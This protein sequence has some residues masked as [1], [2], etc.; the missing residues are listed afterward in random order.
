[1]YLKVRAGW[2]LSGNQEINDLAI[3]NVYQ[4]VYAKED[5]IWDNPTQTYMLR[6]GTAYDI[7]GNDQ[8]QL[9]SGYIYSPIANDNLMGIN[10]TDQLRY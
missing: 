7:A 3:Y 8:G 4:A 5:P 9:P 2:G 1:M 10:R 6:L